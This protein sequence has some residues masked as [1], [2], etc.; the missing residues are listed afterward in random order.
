[1]VGP[2]NDYVARAKKWVYGDVAIDM[3]AGPS[4][5]LVI[6]DDTA[7]PAFVAADLLSQAEHDEAAK[8]ICIAM[9]ESLAEQIA[10]EVN[11]QLTQL[12]RR[13]IAE[14]SIKD[15]GQI[16]VCDELEEAFTIAN[17]IA[18][19]HLQLMIQD[20]SDYIA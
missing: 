17:E 7:D 15:F 6:A 1:I 14:A 5:I 19:E 20:A 4:E 18:P 16:I 11:T 9:D 12:E 8:A 3:I 2:G 13:P 10:T